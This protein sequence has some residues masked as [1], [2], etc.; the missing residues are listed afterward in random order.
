MNEHLLGQKIWKGLLGK[1]HDIS[2]VT[3]TCMWE[4]KVKSPTFLSRMVLSSFKSS[5][6]PFCFCVAPW[7][8]CDFQQSLLVWLLQEQPQ[9]C[10]PHPDLHQHLHFNKILPRF[11]CISEFEKCFITAP[12]APMLVGRLVTWPVTLPVTLLNCKFCKLNLPKGICSAATLWA[13]LHAAPLDNV[14]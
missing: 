13:F 9:L 1:G 5:W 14:S 12:I 4:T 8:L 7:L 11:L 2:E 3:K 6:P 10:L